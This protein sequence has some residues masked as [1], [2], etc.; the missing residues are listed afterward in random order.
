LKRIGEPYLTRRRVAWRQSLHR[1]DGDLQ[2]QRDHSRSRDDG[3]ARDDRNIEVEA[4]HHEEDGRE[5]AEGREPAQPQDGIQTDIPSR[6]VEIGQCGVG[7]GID[8]IASSIRVGKDYPSRLERCGDR[9]THGENRIHL[10][11]VPWARWP[12]R[13]RNP[14]VNPPPAE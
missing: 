8:S 7:H 1:I 6:M 12:A 9:T 10:R 13:R 4:L 14:S 3:D 5:L 11:P 2:R